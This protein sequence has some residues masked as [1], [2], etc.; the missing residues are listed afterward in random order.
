[1]TQYVDSSALVKRYLEEPDASSAR[2]LLAAD[3]EWV[4]ANHAYTEVYR[5]LHIRGAEAERGRALLQL[6]QD[7]QR[8]LVVALDDSLCRRAAEL[9]IVTG[10]RTLD[11]LHLAAAERAGGRALPLLTFDIRQAVAG[12]NLGFTVIGS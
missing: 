4:T 12:R 8:M 1:M 9:S 5:T 7:W 10:T 11:A 6:E 2:E 3:T